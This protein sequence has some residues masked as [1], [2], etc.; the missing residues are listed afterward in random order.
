MYT[1]VDRG[2]VANP[3]PGVNIYY[4]AMYRVM[5][6]CKAIFTLRR[7]VSE[8]C[9]VPRIWG[10]WRCGVAWDEP[11]RCICV[12]YPFPFNHV[13]GFFRNF[14]FKILHNRSDYVRSIWQKGYDEGK[15]FSSKPTETTCPKCKGEMYPFSIESYP[16]K[17]LSLGEKCC[18]CNFIRG[19]IW[20]GCTLVMERWVE[21]QSDWE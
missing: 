14:Y 18:K 6:V 3:Y 5:E 13:L 19:T 10:F 8:G 7:E 4:K 17:S 12:C 11:W 9:I 1:K 21:D 16:D 15:N 2:G 20:N